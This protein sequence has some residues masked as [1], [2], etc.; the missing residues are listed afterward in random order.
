VREPTTT[1]V[2]DE[3]ADAFVCR[4]RRVATTSVGSQ[5]HVFAATRDSGDLY[6]TVRNADGTWWDSWQLVRTFASIDHI[7]TTKV[8]TTIDTAIV[9]NGEIIHAIRASNGTWTGWGNIEGAAGEV[10]DITEVTMAGI[11]SNLHVVALTS[12]YDTFHAIRRA[13]ASWV[14]FREVAVFNDKYAFGASAVNAGGELQLGVCELIDGKQI[15]KHTIRRADGTWQ[16]L[17][18]V[19][20]AGLI[21]ND[22]VATLSLAVTSR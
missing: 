1:S 22:G 9:S 14:R 7:A 15:I 8:G 16:P 19:S 4:R 17:R 11:G 2:S 18:A 10:G 5:L 20:T 21:A 6:H 13:D 12:A 3:V